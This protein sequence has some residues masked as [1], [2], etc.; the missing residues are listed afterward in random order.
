[1]S[2][3]ISSI[4]AA[5]CCMATGVPLEYR[6]IGMTIIFAGGLA[7]LGSEIGGKK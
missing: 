7:G 3:F 4:M 1:M 6:F 5:L 2:L